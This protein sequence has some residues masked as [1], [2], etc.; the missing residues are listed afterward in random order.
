VNACAN[1]LDTNVG[2]VEVVVLEDVNICL[3]LNEIWSVAARIVCDG[4]NEIIANG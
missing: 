1:W 3:N 2:T 4:V